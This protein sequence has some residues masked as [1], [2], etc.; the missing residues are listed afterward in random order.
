VLA[1]TSDAYR[2]LRNSFRY[3]LGA[4]DGFAESERI[5]VGEMP[6][7]ER[8]VLHLMTRLD[9]E[10]KSAVEAFEFNRYARALTDFCNNDLSAFF[11]D[12]R[13]DSLY[14]DA[15]GDPKRRAYR[16]VLDILFHA[17]VRYAAPILCF[18]AEEVW[19]TRFPD[20]GSVHLLEWPEIDA[21]WR[22]DRIEEIWNVVRRLRTSALYSIEQKRREKIIGSSLEC[23]VDMRA[24]HLAVEPKNIDYAEIFIV[25]HVDIEWLNTGAPLT[26]ENDDGSESK[27]TATAVGTIVHPTT[28]HKCGRCWRHLPEVK[29]DGA[30]CDRCEAVVHG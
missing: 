25:S 1:G 4:L 24:H 13:K 21:G 22:D 28:N 2:K 7:L 3:L 9:A 16:T 5:G 18:T 19:G 8:Y 10:L 27:L 12:I 17:L 29:E 14:C 11:F 15:P 20:A 6:D 23:V 26:L 30:L